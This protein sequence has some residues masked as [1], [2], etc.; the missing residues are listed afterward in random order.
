M[1]YFHF[2]T[3]IITQINVQLRLSFFDKVL[4]GD[5]S[6]QAQAILLLRLYIC[7]GRG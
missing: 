6:D 3:H 2:D 4:L 7:D 1:L 5:H